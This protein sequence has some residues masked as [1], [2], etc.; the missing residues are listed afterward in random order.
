MSRVKF[1]KD[2][3][4]VSPIVATLVLIVVAIIGAA[5]VGLIMGT[6]SNNVSSQANSNNVADQASTT[7]L[8]GGSTTLYPAAVNLQK[9]YM[10]QHQGVKITVQQGGSDAGIAGVGM[11]ALTIGMSSRD[12]TQDDLNKYPSLQKYKV[13]GSA[14][15]VI[16]SSNVTV[17]TISKDELKKVYTNGGNSS[18][19]TG[20]TTAVQRADGSG[21]EEVFAKYL[22]AGSSLDSATPAVGV[23]AESQVG[24][25][26]I[27]NYVA[28]HNGAIG[29]VD[30]GYVA[31]GAPTGVKVLKINDGVVYTASPTT[32]KNALKGDYTATGYASGLVKTLFFITNG[33]PT[34][35]VEDFIKYAQSPAGA[36]A[37]E[38]AGMYGVTQFA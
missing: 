18:V 16:C 2:D 34:P 28:T 26:G 29:F 35:L 31:N 36:S 17:D 27:L 5:A 20:I 25:E 1:L 4:A 14:V 8:M 19:P 11:N 37:F 22:G 3:E 15:V 21:T 12:L 38:R 13:G 32:I 23:M 24:N 10:A 7:I 30:W 33:K 6:F 9:D